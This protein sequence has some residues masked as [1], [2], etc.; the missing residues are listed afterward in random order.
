MLYPAYPPVLLPHP[1]ILCIHTHSL[2]V[3]AQQKKNTKRDS[4][5]PPQAFYENYT[6]TDKESQP[7]Y[8]NEPND[9]MIDTDGYD[10]PVFLPA[11][12]DD[13][14]FVD[15][16]QLQEVPGTDLGIGSVVEVNLSDCS[17]PLYG[18]IRWIGIPQCAKVVMVG[19]ELEEDYIDKQLETTNG[20]FNGIP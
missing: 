4:S 20:G 18:V 15:D 13:V 3:E 1:Y 16:S 9:A 8:A 19:V 17:G 6:K 5:Y 14:D 11:V 10:P 12:L 2:T 7:V